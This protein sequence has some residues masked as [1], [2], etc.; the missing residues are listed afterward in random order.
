M[1]DFRLYMEARAK[2][3]DTEGL[4]KFS[5]NELFRFSKK[6]TSDK[7]SDYVKIIE[8]ETPD[9]PNHPDSF[10]PIQSLPALKDYS[11]L[12]EYYNFYIKHRTQFNSITK[13]ANKE[14]FSKKGLIWF[15]WFISVYPW[16]VKKHAS[17]SSKIEKLHSL[18]K[19][20][21]KNPVIMHNAKEFLPGGTYAHLEFFD[22]NYGFFIYTY[23]FAEI[24]VNFAF[25]P[26]EK[27]IS[28]ETTQAC[29]KVP[30]GNKLK[31]FYHFYENIEF[32]KKDRTLQSDGGKSFYKYYSKA[33]VNQGLLGGKENEKELNQEDMRRAK[34]NDL[35]NSNS[36]NKRGSK[37]KTIQD[38]FESEVIEK[39]KDFD[40]WKEANFTD[41]NVWVGYEAKKAEKE[42]LKKLKDEKIQKIGQ[43]YETLNRLI[44]KAKEGDGGLLKNTI[45]T[46]G[47]D[48]TKKDMIDYLK[49]AIAEAGLKI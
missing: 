44:E 7:R 8:D 22:G 43:N 13:N 26:D 17:E 12:E 2:L 14:D 33:K 5:S 45:Q 21:C 35:I 27:S 46:W 31:N 20:D 16:F 23:F 38:S 10:H 40:D 37:L 32:Y 24:R 15:M 42:N 39:E 11:E 1:K 29:P 34:L 3:S 48:P 41:D 47:N 6:P 36:N 9:E 30:T 25:T 4:G 18:L 49:K 28:V 19:K